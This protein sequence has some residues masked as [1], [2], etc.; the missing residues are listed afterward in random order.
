MSEVFEN[1]IRKQNLKVAVKKSVGRWSNEERNRFFG[2]VKTYGFNW[3]KLE[4]TVSTRSSKQIY[5]YALKYF[6]K[7]EVEKG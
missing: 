1:P 3:E 4:Q 7:E 5:N 2:A 6:G